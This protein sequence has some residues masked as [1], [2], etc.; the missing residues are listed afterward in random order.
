M[1][2]SNFWLLFGFSNLVISTPARSQHTELRRRNLRYKLPDGY[3]IN[4]TSGIGELDQ[5]QIYG[6]ILL[7]MITLAYENSHNLTDPISYPYPAITLKIPS[8]DE[9]TQ[10]YRQF[11]SH[12]LYH[13]L[14]TMTASNNFTASKF[15]LQNKAGTV[16]CRKL[17]GSPSAEWQQLIGSSSTALR[18]RDTKH[19]LPQ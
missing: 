16:A 11:A 10:Y 1:L 5:F 15:T 2:P 3:T 9:S 13:A 12:T 17:L 8:A 4:R 18:P 6:A 14:E 19:A 7:A